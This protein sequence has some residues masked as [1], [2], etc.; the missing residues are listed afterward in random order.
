MRK[1]DSFDMKVDEFGNPV[2]VQS[3]QTWFD[4]L[5]SAVAYPIHRLFSSKEDRDDKDR[6]V[7]RFTSFLKCIK[8]W[9]A[10]DPLTG[11][12]TLGL[13][14]EVKPLIKRDVECEYCEVT[15]ACKVEGEDPKVVETK[16]GT[17]IYHIQN[18]T[19][20]INAEVVSQLNTN[21][22]QVLNVIQDQF[23]ATLEKMEEEKAPG[24]EQA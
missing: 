8:I 21:P 12:P 3:Q 15:A 14:F 19:I 10:K 11:L 2:L 5:F 22:M 18:L 13:F 9:P 4:T 24:K 17:I 7:E 23:R 6:E 1:Q 16:H 20:N